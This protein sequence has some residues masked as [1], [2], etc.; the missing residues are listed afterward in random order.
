MCPWCSPQSWDSRAWNRFPSESDSWPSSNYVSLFFPFIT[1]LDADPKPQP[2]F[3]TLWAFSTL[4]K[5]HLPSAT[6]PPAF[7]GLTQRHG[8]TLLLSLSLLLISEE[9]Y[10]FSLRLTEEKK[11]LLHQTIKGV[12]CS[13]TKWMPWPRNIELDLPQIPCSNEVAIS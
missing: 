9:I 3:L 11:Q 10:R 13:E 4:S 7:S 12:V 2:A 1:F 6:Q 5:A 8:L